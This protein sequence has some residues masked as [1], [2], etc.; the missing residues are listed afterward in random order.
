MLSNLP[1]P[2]SIL[3]RRWQETALAL[4]DLFHWLV[5]RELTKGCSLAWDYCADPLDLVDLQTPTVAAKAPGPPLH[6]ENFSGL[7]RKF[8]PLRPLKTVRI[9]LFDFPTVTWGCSPFGLHFV[10]L[11][12]QN[13]PPG[14]VLNYYGCVYAWCLGRFGLAVGGFLCVFWFSEMIFVRS[15]DLGMVS[16]CRTWRSLL[17]RKQLLPASFNERELD[18]IHIEASK[19]LAPCQTLSP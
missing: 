9:I 17:T 11:C 6:V 19:L 7:T 5:V 3:L 13:F 1:A 16:S 12:P 15:I 18:Q 14:T 2:F 10:P 4:S 8:K